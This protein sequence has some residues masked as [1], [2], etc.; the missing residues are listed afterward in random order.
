MISE[1]R[2]AEIK[3]INFGVLH[4]ECLIYDD[5]GW[6]NL[7]KDLEIDDDVCYPVFDHWNAWL[8]GECPV[9]EGFKYEVMHRSG[10]ISR[11]NTI[12]ET[13]DWSSS[14]IANDDIVAY[15][16]LHKLKGWVYHWRVK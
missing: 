6:L 2:K 15:R 11:H 13:N 4:G 9:P 12:C 16:F 3:V 14:T 7:V 8:G 1:E 5:C 10:Q